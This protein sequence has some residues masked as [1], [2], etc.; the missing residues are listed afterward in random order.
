MA[1]YFSRVELP[2]A[3]MM[4]GDYGLHRALWQLFSDGPDRERD[5]LFHQ[6]SERPDSC[7]VVSCRPP[8][9]AEDWSL[10][11]RE[12]RPQL[13]PGQ[14]LAFALR[15]N[16]TV[17][18]SRDGRHSARHDVVFDARRQAQASGTAM[19]LAAA[20]QQAGYGWLESRGRACG[21]ELE[22]ARASGYRRRQLHRRRQGR[23]ILFSTLDYEGVLHV[24]DPERLQRT[25]LQGIGPAKA[26]GCGLLLV[27]RV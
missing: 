25:L 13:K 16:P 18:R 11:T 4:G 3:A 12:Y 17:A 27:R 1:W 21:F 23:L 14:R 24:T 8:R 15:A 19:S 20:E 2:A 6:R 5:F 26:F 9:P 22:Q 10:Q 7:F